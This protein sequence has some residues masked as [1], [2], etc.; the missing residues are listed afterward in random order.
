M[1][2]KLHLTLALAVGLLAGG[3][4]SHSKLTTV[5]AQAPTRRASR[6][7]QR[8]TLTT[9]RGMKWQSSTQTQGTIKLFPIVGLRASSTEQ[10]VTIEL[11]A[12]K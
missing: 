6:S 3:I 8:M 4:L 10:T 1:K 7:E 12:A 5:F 2:Q 9:S 11:T